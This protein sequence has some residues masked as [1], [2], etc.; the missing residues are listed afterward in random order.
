MF[1]GQPKCAP[2]TIDVQLP[3]VLLSLQAYSLAWMSTLV[4]MEICL[5]AIA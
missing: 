4:A 2:L 3:I 1:S 5:L